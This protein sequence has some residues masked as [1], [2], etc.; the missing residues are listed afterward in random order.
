MGWEEFATLITGLLAVLLLATCIALAEVKGDQVEEGLF[1][2][3]SVTGLATTALFWIGLV[4]LLLAQ[5]WNA[6]HLL[7]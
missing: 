1:G 7:G 4:Y 6:F 3:L 2:V 5:I